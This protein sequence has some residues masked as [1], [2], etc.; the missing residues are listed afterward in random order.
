MLR[1][2]E[3]GLSNPSGECLLGKGDLLFI[4][5]ERLLESGDLLLKSGV[6]RLGIGDLLLRSGDRLLGIGDLLLGASGL[7]L[8]GER[9][10]EGPRP[11]EVGE[12][13]PEDLASSGD[14]LTWLSA[15]SV[16]GTPI[17][18]YNSEILIRNSS[19]CNSFIRAVQNGIH[20]DLKSCLAGSLPSGIYCYKDFLVSF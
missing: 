17:L 7:F 15:D 1:L 6:R 9:L 19:S 16:S 8:C 20:S 18:R 3:G 5:G 10:W 14:S 2:G 13:L 4:S 12:R 11:L